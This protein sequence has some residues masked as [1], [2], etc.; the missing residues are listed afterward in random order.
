MKR[1]KYEESAMDI[2]MYQDFYNLEEKHWWF[3]GRRNIIFSVLDKYLPNGSQLRILDV[4]CGTGATL[5][6]LEKYGHTTGV[7]ISG[8]AVKFC[9]L[10]GCRNVYKINRQSLFFEDKM[11][12]VVTALD[13]IEHISDDCAAL[14]EYYRVTKE[15]GILVLTVPA[16]SF[17]WGAHDEINHH[18]RRYVANELKNKVE[19]TGFAVEKLTYFNTFLFPFV[20]LARMVQRVTKMVN[21]GYKPRS[22]LKLHRSHI[23]GVLKT[24]FVL[25]EPLLRKYDFLYGVSLLCVAKKTQYL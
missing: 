3:L 15:D 14:S 1:D 16:Y 24:I 11:F 8:E 19:K 20:L 12:D 25:E 4:G 17:L 18:K 23:N 2:S 10:R 21:G 13:V 22:D 5:R 7:D 9:K 6:K